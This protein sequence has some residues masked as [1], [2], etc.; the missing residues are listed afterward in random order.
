M[1]NRAIFTI[2]FVCIIATIALVTNRKNSNIE[3]AT[4]ENAETMQ[5]KEEQ[6]NPK[7]LTEIVAR[8]PNT[9]N[10][11]YIT[12]EDGIQVPVPKGYV[13]STDAEE[14]Y[15]NGVTTDGVREH[16]GGFVI[17]EKNAG[18]TDEQ[19]TEEI[20]VNLNT[21]KTSRNQYVWVPID[22]VNDMYHVSNRQLYGNTYSFSSTAYNKGTGNN[23]EPTLLMNYDFDQNYLKIYL[24]GISGN[25]FLQEMREEFYKMLESVATYG[26]FYIGRYEIGNI[27]SKVPV[28]R[29]GNNNINNATWYRT[30]KACK[31]LKEG[32]KTVDTGLIWGIQWDETLKWLI[33]S[34][35]KT[36]AEIVDS[37]TWG[38]YSNN[39]AS[40]HGSHR[41][42]GYSEN[43]KAN[44]VYDL[45][46]NMYEWSMERNL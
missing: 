28:V 6:S 37:T 38:N 16:H 46:G 45:A 43:W 42:T 30:Y 22:D 23:M 44:N 29:K 20:V 24:E 35:E 21:A 19:A 14:R 15:V 12:S 34:G 2:V 4:T 27:N 31:N 18:E 5:K 3:I 41:T 9:N 10:L 1:V 39:T 11:T 17:Y 7:A 36:C 8:E 40:G 13:A 32:R 25:E 26:G 33:E